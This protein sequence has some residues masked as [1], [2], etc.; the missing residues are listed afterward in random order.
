MVCIAGKCDNN[1][2]NSS[3]CSFFFGGSPITTI[4]LRGSMMWAPRLPACLQLP[5]D[6]IPRACVERDDGDDV[7]WMLKREKWTIGT[8]FSGGFS[9]A[10]AFFAA[11]TSFSI[12]IFFSSDSTNSFLAMSRMSL[13]SLSH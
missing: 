12:W 7:M 11:S 9:P 6:F 10:A 4:S 3:Y 1:N 2:N 13:L 5:S 8:Y